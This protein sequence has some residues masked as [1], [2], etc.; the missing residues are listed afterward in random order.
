MKTKTIATL[1]IIVAGVFCVTLFV[2][3]APPRGDDVKSHK[4]QKPV[5]LISSLEGV[6]LYK[7]YCATCHGLT[8]KGDGPIA[9]VLDTSPSDLTTISKRN[10]GI[11]PAGRVRKIIAGN[12]L[13]KAHGTREMPIWGPIFHQVER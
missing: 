2:A 4:K 13:I 5:Q 8:G 9:S 10:G 3:A 12:D 11:F 7:S 6:D 1:I